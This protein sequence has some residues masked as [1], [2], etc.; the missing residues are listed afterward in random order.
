MTTAWLEGLL[1]AVPLDFVPDPKSFR[2]EAKNAKVLG[3]LPLDIVPLAMAH[4]YLQ[5]SDD[6]S[7]WHGRQVKTLGSLITTSIRFHFR[8]T[9][10][11]IIGVGLDTEGHWVATSRPT[12]PPLPDSNATT[13]LVVRF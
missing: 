7:A 8:V 12:S 2:R 5:M 6:G 3:L 1:I 13:V 4:A 10:H 9:D 11:P